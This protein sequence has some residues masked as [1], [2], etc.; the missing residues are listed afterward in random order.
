MNVVA[1]ISAQSI[2]PYRVEWQPLAALGAVR[3]EWR[4]LAA[5]ALEP[6]VFYEP[7]FA[8]PAASLFG[9]NV[10]A[11]LVWSHAGAL[12]GL[13]PARV[14]H[15]YGVPLP[16]LTGWT[17]PYAP[18]GTP[19]VDRDDAEAV[20]GAWLDHV[21]RDAAGSSLMLL[22]LVPESGPFADALAAA[23]AR[24]EM[25]SA[26]FGCHRRALLAPDGARV[27][28]LE[29]AIGAK[30][31]KELRRQRHRLADLGTLKIDAALHGAAAADALNDFLALE[32]RGWKGR[33]GTAAANDAG[34]RGFIEGAVEALAAHDKVRID[35]LRLDRNAIAAAITLKSG[36]T[37]WT[38]KIA[39]DEGFARGS[40]GVQLMLDVTEALL[41]DAAI[42][43][44][45]SCAT[46]DHPMIDHLWRE[47]LALSDRLIAVRTPPLPFPLVCRLEALRRTL[48]AKAKALRDAL[49]RWAMANR[50]T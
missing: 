41:A 13:F 14:E 45:D 19:L 11:G 25:A 37:A 36:D 48:I 10:G 42:M 20:L 39:Y 50:T 3:A 35:R 2:A 27:A 29:Q 1:A 28:Y 22:P 4:A 12:L 16:V 44:A 23:L 15:R 46:A 49:R 43:R 5:R 18:L 7:E 47:R 33:A 9:R 38:W 17:H 24:R 30:K 32:A 6:N 8:L 40:P 26:H 34:I 31:R 21:A